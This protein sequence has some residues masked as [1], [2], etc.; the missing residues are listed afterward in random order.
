MFNPDETTLTLEAAQQFQ[1]MLSEVGSLKRLS[2]AQQRKLHDAHDSFFHLVRNLH[3][4]WK[5]PSEPKT[6]LQGWRRVALALRKVDPLW[7]TRATS[8]HASQAVAVSV[9]RLVDPEVPPRPQGQ[10][11]PTLRD[12]VLRYYAEDEHDPKCTDGY[13]RYLADRTNT[14]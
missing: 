12:L 2:K 14:A 3:L 10:P 7:A 9:A 4:A 8:M 1:L 6:E 11:Q 13:F 5:E